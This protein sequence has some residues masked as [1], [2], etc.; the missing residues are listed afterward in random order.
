MEQTIQNPTDVSVILTYRCQMRCKMCDI[1]KYPTDKKKEIT[2]KE[3]EI[4][5]NDVKFV[6]LTGG[7]PFQREDIEDVVEVMYKKAPRI[8]ISTSGWHKERIIK[9]ARKFPNIGIRISIEGLEQTND[10]L[11][12]RMGGYNNGYTLIKEL[13]EMGV[14]DIGFGMT[15]SNYNHHD[16]IPLYNISKELGVEFATA[17]FHNSFYFHK[18][19]NMISEKEAVTEDIEKLINALLK[20]NN[21]KAW[22]RAFFNMGLI[23]YINGGR[24]ML[25]CEAGLVN[26]F[27]EPY[28]DVFP[29]NGLEDAI[30]KQRMGNIREAKDFN[31]IWLGEQARQVREKV[32]KCPK[33][34]WM[35][36]TAAPVM[37]KYMKNPA[38]WVAKNKARSLMGKKV[39]LDHIP[40]YNVGQDPQQGDLLFSR[41]NRFNDG[42]GCKIEPGI[43]LIED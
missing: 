19:D 34:C 33:N 20:E 31:E 17:A 9:L 29:C 30:W 11:R 28:G 26:F 43:Q 35:V 41:M 1:W 7:E 5:P 22:F 8:V 13:N 21:P 6:N 37:K 32:A 36:G 25:P 18:N 2:P 10:M 16:I 12:G 4:L 14:K 24:R 39:C 42:S 23:N 3:L 15:I 40:W 27:I 38:I